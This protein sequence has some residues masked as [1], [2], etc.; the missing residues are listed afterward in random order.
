[1]L[2]I[3]EGNHICLG[4]ALEESDQGNVKSFSLSSTSRLPTNATN[5]LCGFLKRRLGGRS[6]RPIFGLLSVLT[7]L[8]LGKTSSEITFL[9][10][11]MCS[12]IRATGC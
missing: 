1:V 10:D 6:K 8:D 4:T 3:Y 12:E 9:G 7:D 5:Q 2:L 11:F